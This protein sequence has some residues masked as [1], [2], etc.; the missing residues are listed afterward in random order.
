MIDIKVKTLSPNAVVPKYAH[1]TD[2][3]FDLYTSEDLV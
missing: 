2:T 1:P 3:G